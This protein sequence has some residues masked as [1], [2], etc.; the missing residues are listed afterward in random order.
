MTQTTRLRTIDDEAPPPP[1]DRTT[2]AA[3]DIIFIALRALSDRAIVAASTL[4]TLLGLGSACFL[5]F[6]VLPD[7]S[8]NQLIG[9]G[10]Y[11]VLLAAVEII[12]RR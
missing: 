6:Q 9:L 11:G 3:T 5:W 1:Q 4:F 12:R 10:L 8:V 2:K 7:P